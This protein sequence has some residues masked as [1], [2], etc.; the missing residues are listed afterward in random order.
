[1]PRL[2]RQ[3]KRSKFEPATPKPSPLGWRLPV[4][5]GALVL[6]VGG[7]AAGLAWLRPQTG[8]EPQ[9]AAKADGA[10]TQILAAAPVSAT[11]DHDPYP[12]VIAQDGYIRLEAAQYVGGRA[13][14]YAYM[15]G[16]Q[17]IEFFVLQSQDGVIRAAFNACDVCY[18]A[19]RGYL[20][21][22]DS[23]VCQN[24]GRVFPSAKINVVQ[25]GCN[26]APLRR[27][28]GDST[29]VIAVED[30]VEGARLF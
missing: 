10:P 29:V 6:I 19:K 1:M 27:A 22:G 9:A 16:D 8:G 5:L 7:A 21:D 12:Q 25:G 14:H 26:P 24:C 30:L 4:L 20:Q 11:T 13:H 28:V 17:P 2:D 3:T 18:R 15:Q 23:M